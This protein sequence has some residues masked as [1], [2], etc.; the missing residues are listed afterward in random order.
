MD[1]VLTSSCLHVEGVFL[2]TAD[3]ESKRSQYWRNKCMETLT[4][5]PTKTLISPNSKIMLILADGNRSSLN[6]K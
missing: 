1:V 3:C 2:E 5:Q 6:H 4:M